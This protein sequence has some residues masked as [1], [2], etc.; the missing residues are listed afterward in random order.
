MG[1]HDMK[2]RLRKWANE[3]TPLWPLWVRIVVGIGILA[4]TGRVAWIIYMG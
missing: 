1:K 3:D 4:F 2:R